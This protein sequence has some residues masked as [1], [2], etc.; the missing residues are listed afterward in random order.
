MLVIVTNYAVIDHSHQSGMLEIRN[1]AV[2]YRNHWAV[3]NVS[4]SLKAGQMC[5]LIGP[6]GAGKS[7]L[8]KAMLGLIPKSGVVRFDNQPLE[9]QLKRVAYV[10]QRN[11][12]DWHYPVTVWNVVMMGRTRQTGWLRTPSRQSSHL[13]LAALEQVE[14]SQYLRRPIGELS[15]GQQQRVFLARALVQQADLLCF[16]EPFTGIDQKTEAILFD[17]FAQLKAQDKILFVISHDLGE[18]LEPY[19]QFLLL[20]QQLIATGSPKEVLTVNNIERAYGS[21]LHRLAA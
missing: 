13:A 1:L 6:N 14:M 3:K 2:C 18:S 8:V 9:R 16:D 5:A 12:I 19:D 4:F 21:R 10:P 17:V 20:N 7:T 15:G 11:L